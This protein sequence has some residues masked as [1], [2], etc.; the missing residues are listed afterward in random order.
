MIFFFLW[1]F[2]LAVFINILFN[3]FSLETRL[4]L[5][6]KEEVTV[7]EEPEVVRRRVYL[8]VGKENFLKDPYLGRIVIELFDD[9]VPKTTNNFFQLCRDK[10]YKNTPF[11]RVIKDFMIQS[12]DYEYGSGIGGQS[13]YG[14]TFEDENLSLRHDEPGILSMANSGANTNGSQFFYHH[15]SSSTPRW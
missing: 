7:D 2:V 9:I 13:I 6:V 15:K 14:R 8:D 5:P 1:V 10:K 11:H 4:E 3:W 12:G